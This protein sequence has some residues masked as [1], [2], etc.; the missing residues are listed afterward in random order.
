LASTCKLGIITDGYL[1]TQEKKVEAL[2][3]KERF[4][5]IILSDLFG[6]TNWKPSP[7]PYIKSSLELNCPHNECVYIG[8]NLTK[9]F[10]TAKKLGWKTVHIK[11]S[12]GIYSNT[13]VSKEFGAHYEIRDLR[14]LQNILELNKL[15]K[16]P[17]Q[18]VVIE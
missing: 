3:L 4:N 9:D 10:I 5:S 18:K 2:K 13:L 15:F 16:S 17:N 8:D 6:R 7:I 14:E 11:R 1:T 12:D